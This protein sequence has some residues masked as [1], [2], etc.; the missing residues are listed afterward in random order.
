MR[1][2]DWRKNRIVDRRLRELYEYE[3]YDELRRLM[4][5]Q[6][7]SAE[8]ETVLQQ[9]QPLLATTTM[10]ATKSD[11]PVTLAE[12]LAAGARADA[13]LSTISTSSTTKPKDIPERTAVVSWSMRDL[14]DRP[15]DVLRSTDWAQ[16]AIRVLPMV[17]TEEEYE[18]RAYLE[19]KARL[20]ETDLQ[21]LTKEK[22]RLRKRIAMLE[23]LEKEQQTEPPQEDQ[24]E[25]QTEDEEAQFLVEVVEQTAE[26]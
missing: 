21:E 14:L 19:S 23:Q 6:H 12:H 16:Q 9:S 20:L 4:G 5:N 10:M 2:N 15:Y 7:H 22:R 13:P 3:R 17:H 25:D 18:R 8:D 11:A 26:Q 24:T 1:V